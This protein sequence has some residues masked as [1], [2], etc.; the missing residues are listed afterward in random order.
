MD[1]VLK[2][3]AHSRHE[4]HKGQVRLDIIETFLYQRTLKSAQMAMEDGYHISQSLIKSAHQQLLSFGRGTDKSPGMFKTEQNYLAD[5]RNKTI[6]FIPISAERLQEGLDKLF[7]FIAESDAPALIKA[8]LTHVEFE[9]LHPFK[10]G[11][12]RIGR[13]LIPLML[14]QSGLISEPHFY[15]SGYLQEHK[16]D[17]IDVMRNVSKNNDWHSWCVFFLKAVKAQ[18]KQN[19]ETVQ[20]IRELY[21]DMKEEFSKHLASKWYVHALDFIFTYPI[22]RNSSFIE[23]SGIPKATASKFVR[24]L[25]DREILVVVEEG[26]GRRAAMYA[27][28]P[29]MKLVRV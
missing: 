3:E 25:L 27:F 5:K 17:Y 22:F 18:A 11:N 20:S 8:A 2:L 9:A 14:W 15:I 12:G 1:E 13:I 23:K 16:D 24:I 7:L 26:A 4:N 21:E 29:L 10:D 28:E 19:L 6:L